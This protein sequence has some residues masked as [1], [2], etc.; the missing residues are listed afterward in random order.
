MGSA[1]AIG[2]IEAYEVASLADD[3][4]YNE[5]GLIKYDTL[6]LLLNDLQ[7]QTEWASDVN[8]SWSSIQNNAKPGNIVIQRE[9]INDGGGNN[10]NY[11]YAVNTGEYQQDPTFDTSEA[12]SDGRVWATYSSLERGVIKAKYKRY[13][14]DTYDAGLNSAISTLVANIM[15]NLVKTKARYDFNK[16][17]TNTEFVDK[18]L[19]A[20][21]EATTA[22]VEE[23]SSLADP[24]EQIASGGTQGQY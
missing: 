18:N 20:F 17:G 23:V 8:N 19:T 11:Y 21:V 14:N 16:I 9:I 3:T 4:T 7:A 5:G 12:A 2:I 10:A 13:D 22:G 1:S 6:D 24:D 15:K